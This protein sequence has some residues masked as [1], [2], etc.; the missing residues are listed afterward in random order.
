MSRRYI[1]RAWA[2]IKIRTWEF[3][4]LWKNYSFT[5]AFWG[6][7][8]WLCFYL[9]MPF[10]WKLSTLAIRKKTAWLDKYMEIHYIDIIEKYKNYSPVSKQIGD[11]R[12]WVFWGQ[13][14]I[15]MPPLIK[16][17]H[18]QLTYFNKNITLI[19]SQNVEQ[20]IN[21]PSIIYENVKD[22]L[23]SWAHFS[24][25]VRNTLL[26]QYGGLWLDA[27]VW[28]SGKLPIDKF[29]TMSI[30]SAN[31]IF[32]IISKFSVRYWSS[33]EYNWNSWCLWSNQSNHL[34]FSFVSDMLC[35]IAKNETF[36]PDY[37]IQ[38][39]LIYYAC[40]KFP[41][42]KK[43]FENIYI[44]NQHWT[45]LAEMMNLPYSKQK[46]NNLIQTDYVFKL[47]FRSPWRIK[48]SKGEQTFYGRILEE[49]IT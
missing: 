27:T 43:D 4:C 20:Y 22:G 21:L 24:D 28:V 35:N 18:R 7:I 30:Y 1:K 12:I 40:R 32:P 23:I 33:F 15:Q 48:T 38:D 16:A 29:S 41:S 2:Y 6:I 45:D 19:S 36:W 37:V 25:I 10:N 13:G 44:H 8:W 14:E 5:L 39:Y 42:V 26:A 49:I 17:C 9:H 31:V 46:Y 47:S 3:I 11:H 34:L